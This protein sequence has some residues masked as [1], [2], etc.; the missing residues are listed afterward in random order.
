[1]R[2]I[3]S[4]FYIIGIVCVVIAGYILVNEFFDS[5]DIKIN[6]NEDEELELL[7]DRLSE[8]GSPLGWI[9]L[10]DGINNQ[11]RNGKYVISFDEDLLDNYGYRQLFVMEYILSISNNYDD[12]IVLDMDGNIVDDIPTSEFTLTYLEYDKYNSYY[13]NLFGEEFNINKSVKGNTE[14]D[15]GYVYYDNRRS[16]S[17]GVYVSMMQATGI[18]YNNGIFIGEVSVTYSTRAS[19][20]VGSSVDTA[21]IEYTKDINGNIIIKSFILRDR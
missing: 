14:Y 11:D 7:N 4:L 9:V 20:L 5:V 1:M 16:G 15:D 2:K 21:I 8:I 3:N 13:K 18:E 17:N 10:V 12:F 19:E 6:F